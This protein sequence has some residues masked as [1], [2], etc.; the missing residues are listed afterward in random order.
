MSL[1]DFLPN[2]NRDMEKAELGTFLTLLLVLAGSMLL[3][4]QIMSHRSHY[5]NT[6][7]VSNVRILG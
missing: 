1:T 7:V 2:E 3:L 6:T 4:L 5:V